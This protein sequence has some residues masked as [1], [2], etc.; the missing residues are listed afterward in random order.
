MD[1]P[2]VLF[3]DFDGP[4]A[5]SRGDPHPQILQLIPNLASEYILCLASFN[6]YADRVLAKWGLAK[7]FRAF[8]AGSHEAPGRLSYYGSWEDMD[9]SKAEQITSILEEELAE[10]DRIE[11]AFFDDLKENLDEV[12]KD[13]DIACYLIDP[14]VGLLGKDV[15]GFR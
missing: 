15:P 14:E 4:L 3:L 13:L 10:Y 7:Y 9:L 2:R 5:N 8:R 1:T 11:A 12:E 6:P